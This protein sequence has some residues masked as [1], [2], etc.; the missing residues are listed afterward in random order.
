M[1]LHH[2]VVVLVFTISASANPPNIVL[3]LADDLGY[4]DL[5][6]Y[7]PES[8]IPTP[9]SDRLA[10]DGIIFTD[11][12]SP[13]AVC[14]PT[15]YSLLT[16]RYAW[17]TELKS[18]VLWAFDRPLIKP[19]EN[20]LPK[21]LEG[22]GYD[23]ACIGKWHLGWD[24]KRSDGAPLG[25]PFQIGERGPHSERIRL[26]QAVDYSQ[27]V[28][29]GPLG[30]GFSNYFGDD[31]INQ[32]PYLWI[33]DNRCLTKP[34]LPQLPGILRGSSNGPALEGW[35]QADVLPKVTERAVGYI[36]ERGKIPHQPFFLYFPLTAPHLPIVVPEG[37]EGKS[38]Y[39]SKYGAYGDFVHYI[40]WIVGQ[41]DQALCESGLQEDTL[42]I[43][44]SDNGSFAEPG[45]G[46]LANG[47][48]RG[49]KASIFE[50]GHRVPLVI[51]WPGKIEKG[52]TNPQL[53]G[54]NDF[55][56]TFAAL[57]G[58]E[59]PACA[60]QDSVNLLP[61]FRDTEVSVR[62]SLV[63]HSVSGEFAIR[64]GKWKLIP[65]RKMLFDLETDIGEEHNLWEKH[66]KI[67]GR[68][69]EELDRIRG[70]D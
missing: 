15:R 2:F 19:G 37:F 16:G 59:L 49:A 44:T 68:L 43:F 31:V 4:G 66:P 5:G 6:C 42:V 51:R 61:T 10:E 53:V 13:S 25:L 60:A 11:A 7:N 65:G 48:L 18:L 46:H 28:G 26:A 30:A 9:H 23:T 58:Q 56:A 36:Q 1:K 57:L 70:G 62:K 22:A 33:E 17:R 8:K 21:L 39:V 3:I 64:N 20:T 69:G 35:K 14:S 47:P 45:H 34:T 54:L 40:D 32:P 63:H 24:W 38:S 12:H 55:M 29:G 52:M 67:V 41:L 50:G 27:P